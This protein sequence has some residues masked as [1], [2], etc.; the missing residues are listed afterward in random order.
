MKNKQ[1]N[2]VTLSP[3]EF[4]RL[5]EINDKQRA[6]NELIAKRKSEILAQDGI[7]A[8]FKDLLGIY[9]LQFWL[10]AVN[11]MGDLLQKT[12]NIFNNQFIKEK[13]KFWYKNIFIKYNVPKELPM[14]YEKDEIGRYKFVIP[15]EN[16]QE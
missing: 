9:K 11:F 15:Q 1:Q 8:D 3:E 14:S 12:Q 2:K 10:H 16:E 5:K 4:Q 6:R 13:N 7:M